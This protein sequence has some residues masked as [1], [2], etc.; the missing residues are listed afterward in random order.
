MDYFQQDCAHIA[1]QPE[2][3][4]STK[5]DK[6]TRRRWARA[7]AIFYACLI[8]VGA[9][10]IGVTHRNLTEQHASLAR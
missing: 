1:N 10:A 4:N 2:P 7:V 5:E 9:T 3:A 6:T 8:L